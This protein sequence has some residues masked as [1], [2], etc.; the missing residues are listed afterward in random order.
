MIL[1]FAMLI[2]DIVLDHLDSFLGGDAEDDD[3]TAP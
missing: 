1:G 3:D 2:T